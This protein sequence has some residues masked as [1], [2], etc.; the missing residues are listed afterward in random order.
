MFSVN[1]GQDGPCDLVTSLPTY[2]NKQEL[3]KIYKSKAPEPSVIESTF[4]RL[5]IVV[6]GPR[7]ENKQLPW[8]V[9]HIQG[10]NSF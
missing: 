7:K 5:M 1:Y 10:T 3:I 2:L 9:M 6:F 4:Y 8:L